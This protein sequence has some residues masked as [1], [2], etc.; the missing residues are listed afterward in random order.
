M[1]LTRRK[2]VRLGL[3]GALLLGTGGTL[4]SMGA[5]GFRLPDRKTIDIRFALASDG[6]WGQP[7]TEYALHHN[8]MIQWLNEEKKGRGINF[9]FI[10]G[11]IFHDNPV[12]LPPVAKAWDQL[13]MPWYASHGNHDLIDEASWIQHCNTAWNHSFELGKYAFVVLNT[14][15]EKGEYTCPNLDWVR[16]R[17]DR[18]Q[19]NKHLVVFMHI[20][21]FRWTNGGIDCASLVA[22]F[23][24]QANLKLIFHGHDHDQDDVKESAGKFYFFDSHVAGNWGTDY[25]GY[26][27]VEMLK[28]GELITYQMNPLSETRINQ[29]T[30]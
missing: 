9:T 30:L 2:F 10:N 28:T 5:S 25:R 23:N 4:R 17:L 7:D 21:P 14:A 12:F 20:T 15:S 1:N 19:A 24:E 16:E 3:R 22:L 8:N 18:Y 11:D 13:H 29:N 26:R 27:I 6:H